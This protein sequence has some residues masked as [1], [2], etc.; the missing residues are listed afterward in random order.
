MVEKAHR[1][2]ASDEPAS[3]AQFY[4]KRMRRFNLAIVLLALV[5][6]TWLSNELWQILT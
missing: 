2:L 3:W 1:T 6:I 4:E 5:A